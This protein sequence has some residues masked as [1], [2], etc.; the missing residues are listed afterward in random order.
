MEEDD[1]HGLDAFVDMLKTTA[2]AHGYPDARVGISLTDVDVEYFNGNEGADMESATP[3][4]DSVAGV[5]DYPDGTGHV[6]LTGMPG[7]GESVMWMPAVEEKHC[8]RPNGT[9]LSVAADGT[10]AKLGDWMVEFGSGCARD[11]WDPC[12]NAVAIG[13]HVP[14]CNTAAVDP[15][16]GAAFGAMAFYG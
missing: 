11:A 16:T 8:W 7:I 15:A 4:I 1:N 6:R 12:K 5:I 10:Q 3:M 14:H 2:A 9:V 13:G